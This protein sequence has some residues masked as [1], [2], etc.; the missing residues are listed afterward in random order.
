MQ[1]GDLPMRSS[2]RYIKSALKKVPGGDLANIVLKLYGA[3]PFRPKTIRA[4][5]WQ[6]HSSN[7]VLVD[8]P[9]KL[10]GLADFE[11]GTGARSSHLA[12]GQRGCSRW[13]FTAGHRHVIRA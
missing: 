12:A 1:S 11:T 8:S 3:L 6:G 9:Q 5:T 7:V 4:A 13:N 2:H 10:T